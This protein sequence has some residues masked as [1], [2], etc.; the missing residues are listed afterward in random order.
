MGKVSQ[1]PVLFCLCA[2][3][4]GGTQCHPLSCKPFFWLQWISCRTVDYTVKL[5]IEA[6][7][8]GVANLEPLTDALQSPARIVATGFAIAATGVAAACAGLAIARIIE[9]YKK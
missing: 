8:K 1:G 4:C 3:R 2:S 9:A 5:Q 7:E 6:E